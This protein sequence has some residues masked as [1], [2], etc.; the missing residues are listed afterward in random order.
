MSREKERNTRSTRGTGRMQTLLC[1]LC[2]LCSVLLTGQAQQRAPRLPKP[3]VKEPGVQRQMTTITPIAVFPAEGTP[4]WQVL[5]DDAVWVTNG[6]KNTVHRLDVKSNTVSAVVEVGKRPCSG[7]AW[8]FGSVWV[9]NCGDNTLSRIETKT[10]RV[11][12]TLRLVRPPVKAVLPPAW[13]RSG[14]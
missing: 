14:C 4:D 2:L 1:F 9:P 10:N 7:L 13:I 5:T 3:G 6:P 8:G 12:A 11:V